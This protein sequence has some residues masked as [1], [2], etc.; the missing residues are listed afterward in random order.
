MK[1]LHCAEHT[2]RAAAREAGPERCWGGL[3]PEGE[4]MLSSVKMGLKWTSGRGWGKGGKLGQKFR[5]LLGAK[6]DLEP[7]GPGNGR[8]MQVRHLEPP[9]GPVANH[10]LHLPSEKD[11]KKH[12]KRCFSAPGGRRGHRQPAPRAAAAAHERGRAVEFGENAL[13]GWGRGATS[14][15]MVDQ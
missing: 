2:A 13:R 14:L 5:R 10:D 15:T 6:Q 12:L 11:P 4:A 8:W 9:I 7:T 3:V 1:F